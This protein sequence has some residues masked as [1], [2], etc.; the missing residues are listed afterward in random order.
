MSFAIRPI[1]IPVLTSPHHF[2]DLRQGS[3]QTLWASG[4]GNL[5]LHN[6]FWGLYAES[7]L[8]GKGK[9]IVFQALFPF[10]R[11]HQL[12]P[13]TWTPLGTETHFRPSRLSSLCRP[14]N[15]FM[16][17]FLCPHRSDLLFKYVTI[18]SSWV[19]YSPGWMS[20]ALCRSGFLKHVHYWPY[21]LD[22]FFVVGAVLY[23]VRCLATSL[24]STH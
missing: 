23:I 3:L 13:Y 21:G 22:N 11:A 20:P 1:P 14:E 16:C 7:G 9:V 24:A 10:H 5:K 18:L 2:C 17:N 6:C 12:T 15:L 4:R 19:F 8:D